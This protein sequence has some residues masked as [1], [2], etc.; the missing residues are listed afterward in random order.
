MS[1]EAN[2]DKILEDFHDWRANGAHLLNT[3]SESTFDPE[4]LRPEATQLVK[5]F[6][7]LCGNLDEHRAVS[8]AL[9][10]IKQARVFD[11]VR[12]SL[13]SEMGLSFSRQIEGEY[14]S[15][16]FPLDSATM[17]SRG[18]F[19]AGY[20]APIVDMV[21]APE[22]Y[23]RGTNEGTQYHLLR[24]ITKLDVV[25]DVGKRYSAD[26]KRL[27]G[28]QIVFKNVEDYASTKQQSRETED[29][30]I[31]NCTAIPEDIT[32]EDGAALAMVAYSNLNDLNVPSVEG[33]PHI[34]NGT[35]TAAL[36]T[37]MKS[38]CSA[39]Q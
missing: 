35:Q 37:E 12:R 29:A 33:N 11:R 27:E 22:L 32:E 20:Q 31:D 13:K 18:R 4:D 38:H 39:N 25:C 30:R 10:I 28:T 3:L 6:Q 17:E 14:C 36:S 15:F 21:T 5:T 7:R 19:K 1:K 23:K 8:H 24:Q 34:A 9:E 2:S 26:L 16:G